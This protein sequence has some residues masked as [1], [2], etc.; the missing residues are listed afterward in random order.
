[1]I[2]LRCS[3][4]HLFIFENPVGKDALDGEKLKRPVRIRRIDLPRWKV[5]QQDG[6]G[7]AEAF[8]EEWMS[9]NGFHEFVDGLWVGEILSLN[10]QPGSLRCGGGFFDRQGHSVRTRG[11]DPRIVDYF[12]VHFNVKKLHVGNGGELQGT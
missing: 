4:V 12:L 8:F 11:F 10:D 9:G 1:M 5:L 3:V 2:C 6:V 7:P